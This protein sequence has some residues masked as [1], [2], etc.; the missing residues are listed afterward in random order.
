MRPGVDLGGTNV[1]SSLKMMGRLLKRNRQRMLPEKFNR[2]G[3]KG[4]QDEQS[5]ILE[6]FALK[7]SKT[8]CNFVA[9]KL[10]SMEWEPI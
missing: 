7:P 10:K 3:V 4:D 6:N 8:A 1:F 2:L 9:C 5:L